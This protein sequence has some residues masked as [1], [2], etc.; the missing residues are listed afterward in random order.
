MK[1]VGIEQA[2][3]DVCVRE[4]QQDRV[5]VTREGQPVALIV[6]IE[7][8]DAEQ[9]ELGSSDEFWKMITERRGQKTISRSELEQ[10]AGSGD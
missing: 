9:V 1:T 10:K 8:M 7:G 5:L 4:A 2:T 3:L 6:G